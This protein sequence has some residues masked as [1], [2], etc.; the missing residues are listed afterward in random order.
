M[1]HKEAV[2]GFWGVG[3]W[4]SCQKVVKDGGP[5]RPHLQKKNKNHDSTPV[6]CKMH[7]N[8]QNIIKEKYI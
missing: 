6:V 8:H 1:N 7:Q 2:L 5:H 3:E 4:G